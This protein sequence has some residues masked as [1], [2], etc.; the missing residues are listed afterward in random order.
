MLHLF[1]F[2]R[3]GVWSRFT[4]FFTN[5][6]CMKASD[7]PKEFRDVGIM[8][9]YR[10]PDMPV[11]LYLRS[12]FQFHNETLNVWTHIA[13][14]LFFVYYAAIV[15][16]DIDLLREE[17]APLL[18]LL[19]TSCLFPFGSAL[20]HLF[21]SMSVVSRHVCFMID[22]F[23]ISL[24]AY[25]ACA[26]NKVYAIPVS[27]RGSYFENYFMSAMFFNCVITV[28]VSCYTR[29]LPVTRET[30]ILRLSAF[31]MPYVFG[32]L[33][34]MH[35]VLHCEDFDSCYGAQFYKQ[36]FIDN[37]FT[38]VFYGGHVPEI[39]FPGVFDIFFHSH[40]IFH[41]VV[42]IATWHHLKGIVI[43]SI[44]RPANHLS[45]LAVSPIWL[46]LLL[47]LINLITVIH[48]SIKMS[49]IKKKQSQ[50]NG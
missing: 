16:R 24:Y 4:T 29:F 5:P 43:D 28:V 14:C 9:G 44:T 30:K 42:V 50:K 13:S 36:H 21:N 7:L 47:T 8:S 26:A 34:C 31:V 37:L 48:F 15:S 39:F 3:M 10:K 12:L 33:P 40:Q 22:Y 46:L 20:A 49:D 2:S 11:R 1:A 25:G 23:T 41:V 45:L 19:I 32:M 35:R 38:I 6:G 17:N 27:W 18:C